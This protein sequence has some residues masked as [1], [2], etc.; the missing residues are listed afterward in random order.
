MTCVEFPTAIDTRGSTIG[1]DL[2]LNPG[3]AAWLVVRF[4]T[5]PPG[6]FVGILVDD[7][8]NDQLC[9]YL[10]IDGGST[11]YQPD[12]VYGPKFDWGITVFTN[13]G[14]NAVSPAAPTWSTVKKL[15]DSE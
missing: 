9:D 4:I 15:Y 2:I 3:A 10:T 5:T 12:P 6:E 11:W 8:A 14:Q 7:D 13:T 1:L